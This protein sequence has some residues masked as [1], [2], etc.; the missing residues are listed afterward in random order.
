[1]AL[2]HALQASDD[3]QEQHLVF[4]MYQAE[5]NKLAQ[6]VPFEGETPPDKLTCRASKRV[7]P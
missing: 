5:A 7:V 1:M 6:Q 4:K 2:E 3:P